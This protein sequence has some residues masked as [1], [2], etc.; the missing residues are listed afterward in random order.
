MM[1]FAWRSG[2]SASRPAARACPGRGQTQ[3]RDA[4]C[5]F[6][7]FR[8]RN[9]GDCVM[10]REQ[11]EQFAE[12][13]AVDELHRH[14]EEL[15][16]EL[17]GVIVGLDE[18]IEQML[19]AILC[20]GHCILEGM[21]GLAK[22]LLVST[23]SSLLHLKFRRV[24]FTPDLMPADITGTDILEE[25]HT[26]G[27]RVFRFVPGPLFGN[28]ILAD[29]INRTPPKTQSALLEAMQERQLTIGGQTHPLPDPFFV[30]ATQNPIEHEGTYPLPEAQLDRFLF[31]LKLTYPTF[32][33]EIEICKRATT[34]YAFTTKPVL[35]G[36][37]LIRL[38][39]LVR[40]VPVADPVYQ[41]AVQLVRMTRPEEPA[42]PEALREMV[43]W[44][45]GPR[46]SICL[47]LAA[48]ARAILHKRYH[49]TTADVQAM[50][51]PVLRHRII[52]TFNAEAAGVTNDD[53]I[54][55]VDERLRAGAARKARA[56]EPNSAGSHP[57]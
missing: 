57:R 1:R 42:F 30:L 3:E 41:Y 12:V 38:Q 40:K 14:Y 28:I 29:E 47:L 27:K 16:G 39:D 51:L 45:A 33:H 36:E 2:L 24:Q 20:R 52:P 9:S 53:I 7:A 32:D 50:A 48:K 8:D 18:V 26:T 10:T 6:A 44:G 37:D 55:Q 4:L 34:Q 21:P 15:R 23:V 54:R 31:K 25:D 22:T 5:H 11:P 46:A 35:S 56:P 17:R 49:A 19:V 43:Q 13:Q